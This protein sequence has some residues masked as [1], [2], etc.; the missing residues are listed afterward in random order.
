MAEASRLVLD[1]IV[2]RYGVEV[3]SGTR[4]DEVICEG[5]EFCLHVDSVYGKDACAVRRW[6]STWAGA[7]IHNTLSMILLDKA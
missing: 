2:Q 7:R 4:L 6:Y 5:D 1:H 3:W